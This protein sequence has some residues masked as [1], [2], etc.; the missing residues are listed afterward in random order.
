[1]NGY[2]CEIIEKNHCVGGECTGWRRGDFYVDNCIHWMMGTKKN[3]ELNHAWEEVGALDNNTEICYPE[4]FYVSEYNGETI[5]LWNDLEKTIEEMLRIS[6]EDKKEIYTFRKNVKRSRGLAMPVQA[7]PELMTKKQLIKL[8]LPMIKILPVLK[9]YNKIS[10]EDYAKFFKHPLLRRMISDYLSINSCASSLFT[11][12][13]TFIDGDGGI[14]KGF[15]WGVPH[16]MA[17]KFLELG[18]KISLNSPVT[19]ISIQGDTVEGVYTENDYHRCDKIIFATDFEVTYSLL[20]EQYRPEQLK[21]A[22]DDFDSFPVHSEFQIA[23]FTN[24]PIDCFK[25]TF[26]FETDEM[27]IGTRLFTRLGVRAYD[28][29]RFAPE[30]KYL[31]Q[32]CLVQYKED[33]EFWKNLAEKND[34]SYEKVKR[35]HAETLVKQIEKRANVKVELID[36][37]TPY[38]YNKWCGAYL[39]SYMSFMKTPTSKMSAFPSKVIGL[40]NCYIGSQ[41][42]REPGGLATALT[43]GKFAA[44]WINFDERKK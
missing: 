10:V 29:D 3:T 37:W 4:A 19:R 11:S 36:I 30:G 18:G 27:T 13:A 20:G 17:N 28:Y 23:F 21:K 8:G 40:S 5:T 25:S 7:P 24:E 35:Q 6:P 39:G 42:Q 43:M 34:G 26:V 9:K 22:L 33:Y 15:S 31:Y 16:R 12:Y 41:W 44:Q 32:C 1:M 38:T 14:P 2:D